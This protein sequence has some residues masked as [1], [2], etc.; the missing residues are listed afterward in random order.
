MAEETPSGAPKGRFNFTK[1]VESRLPKGGLSAAFGLIVGGGLLTWAGL[2]SFYNVPGGSRAIKF[3]RFV[4]VRDRQFGEGTHLMIPWIEWPI[5]Y[6]VRM[7]P[8]ELPSR[9][10][11]KDL[12]MVDIKLRMLYRPNPNALPTIYRQLGTNF[13]DRVL[14]SI[15]NEVLKSVVAQFNASQL[16]TKREHVSQM[17]KRRLI[18]RAHDFNIELDD[19]SI[20]HISFGPDYTHAIELKQVAQQEAERARYKV[21][22]ARQIKLEIIAKAEGE[23]EAARKF[24]RQ[25]KSDPEGNFLAF[26]RIEA[27]REIAKTVSQSR[28]TVYIS[29]D[30]LMMDLVHMMDAQIER[31]RATADAS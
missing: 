16:L 25:L 5:I 30:N 24:N 12:Q 13:K 4:G 21:E 28:N 8:F 10:G 19:V 3:N 1:L 20:T 18:E 31:T 6:S 22:E 29:S 2:N 26:K 9:T 11:S 14:P 17:M 27:A 7:K 15:A 23:A